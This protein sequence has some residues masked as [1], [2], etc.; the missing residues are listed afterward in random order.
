MLSFITLNNC[1]LF[2]VDKTLWC[3]LLHEAV[4]GAQETLKCLMCPC[5]HLML[6]RQHPCARMGQ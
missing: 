6:Q 2:Y 5:E 1:K 4:E 3:N